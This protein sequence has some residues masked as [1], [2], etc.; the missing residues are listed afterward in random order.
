MITMIIVSMYNS[1]RELR[2]CEYHDCF[3]CFEMREILVEFHAKS[4]K[5]GGT[6]FDWGGGGAKTKRAL[7]MC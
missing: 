5:G 1:A 4:S 3:Q 6:Y 2:F 7:E